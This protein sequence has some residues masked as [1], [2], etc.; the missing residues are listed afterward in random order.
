MTAHRHG[1][2]GHN[3][4]EPGRT[5]LSLQRLP[6]ESAWFRVVQQITFY[7]RLSS[8]LGRGHGGT[9]RLGQE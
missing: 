4:D 1:S 8:R 6:K 9:G 7:L 5:R 3:S 2:G